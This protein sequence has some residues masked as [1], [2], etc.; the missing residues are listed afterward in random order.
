MTLTLI[1][2]ILNITTRYTPNTF[3]L[4]VLIHNRFWASLHSAGSKYYGY[5]I[6]T[7]LYSPLFSFSLLPLTLII[8]SA[9]NFKCTNIPLEM[10]ELPKIP[11]YVLV[12]SCESKKKKKPQKETDYKN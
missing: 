3:K 11:R 9:D 8:F 4:S 2:K 5:L 1:K 6:I 10:R 12:N 7:L